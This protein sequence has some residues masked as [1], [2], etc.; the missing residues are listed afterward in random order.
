MRRSAADH[1]RSGTSNRLGD[2]GRCLGER[3]L[4]TFAPTPVF[5]LVVR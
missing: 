5:L 1:C 2:S 4:V 3:K